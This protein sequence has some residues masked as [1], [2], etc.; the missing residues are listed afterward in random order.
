MP[1]EGFKAKTTSG[2]IF[3]VKFRHLEALQ[4]TF[5]GLLT[6]RALYLGLSQPSAVSI[7]VLVF[8]SNVG[9]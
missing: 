2:K 3:S 9:D 1:L 6:S 7:A 5:I 4:K 8:M